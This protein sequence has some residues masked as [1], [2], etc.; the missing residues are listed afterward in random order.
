MT[1]NE[2]VLLCPIDQKLCII[3]INDLQLTWLKQLHSFNCDYFVRICFV[4]ETRRR[5]REEPR[6]LEWLR[7]LIHEYMHECAREIHQQK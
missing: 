1:P 4:V 5:Y 7:T 6:E 3:Q 2:N